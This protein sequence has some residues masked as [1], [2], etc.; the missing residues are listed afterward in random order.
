MLSEH[1]INIF[2]IRVAKGNNGG[3]WSEHYTEEQ[4]AHWRRFVMDLANTIKATTDGD[5][6]DDETLVGKPSDM[7]S[8][9]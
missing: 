3:L 4:R 5:I 8:M 9:D 2:A 7:P 1:Q 6:Y